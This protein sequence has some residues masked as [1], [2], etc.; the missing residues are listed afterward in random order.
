MDL[1]GE[2]SHRIRLYQR[3]EVMER[4]GFHCHHHEVHALFDELIHK[5]WGIG[6]WNPPVDIWEKKDAFIIEMDLPGLVPDQ[7]RIT[8]QDR[9]LTVEGQRQPRQNAGQ[10]ASRLHE[11]CE[12]RFAR[13][14][15]FDYSLEGKKIES[16]WQD[17]VLTLIVPKS[18]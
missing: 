9:T 1:S 10:V 15:E 6:C 5:P 12:G 16:H 8:A 4:Q 11:R 3:Q 17:G 2:H 18:K 13:A 7:V 14:F